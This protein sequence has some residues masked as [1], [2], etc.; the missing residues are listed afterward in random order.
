VKT[1]AEVGGWED[2]EGLNE[3]VGDCLVTCEVWVELVAF[4][5]EGTFVS[6]FCSRMKE[7]RRCDGWGRLWLIRNR[8]ISLS[9]RKFILFSG[10]RKR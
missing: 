1:E 5:L 2:G 4:F 10:N 8:M 6:S 7:G 9:R 3:D